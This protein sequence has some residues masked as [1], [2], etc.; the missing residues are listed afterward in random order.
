MSARLDGKVVFVTGAGSA[1]PGWGNGKAAAALFAREGARVFAIDNRANALHETLQIVR[2]EG[3]R[4]DGCTADVTD[5]ASVQ[6]A[7]QAC[8]AAFGRLDVLHNNVGTY[9]L[10]GPEEA[11]EE[12]WDRVHDINLKS[13]FLTCKHVLPVMAGQGGGSIINISSISGLTPSLRTPPYGAVKAAVIQ[14]TTTQALALAK[15]KIRVNCIA[16]GSIFFPGGTWDNAKQNN[17]QLYA[18]IQRSIPWDRYGT[19]EEVANVAMF[20]A[21]D[22]A[23][24]VT[25]QTI[26]VDG[27]QVLS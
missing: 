21:S 27:G 14:Y 19:P 4:I 26:A 23:S 20:L 9:E 11:S 13:A 15:K 5:A 17:P 12:S 25:G 7:V 10:G 24:W 6:Q 16:P 18:S 3:G 8:T 2:G 22:M 1:G